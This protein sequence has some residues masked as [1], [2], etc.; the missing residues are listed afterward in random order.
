VTYGMYA[1]RSINY[2]RRLYSYRMLD[3]KLNA[4]STTVHGVLLA[5]LLIYPHSAG[6]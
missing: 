6:I 2:L 1:M 3:D 5:V 4:F